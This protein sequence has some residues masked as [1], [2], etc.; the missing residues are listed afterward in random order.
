MDRMA[1]S[2]KRAVTEGACEK[3][4]LMVLQPPAISE[5]DYAGQDG[6]TRW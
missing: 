5:P 2:A 6:I 1:T 4:G 3:S